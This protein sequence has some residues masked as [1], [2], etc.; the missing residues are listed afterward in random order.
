MVAL[1]LPVLRDQDSFPLS[2]YPMYAHDRGREVAIATAIGVT[3]TG[4]VQR[5]SLTTIADADDPLEA[6]SLVAGEVRAG[7]ADVL[8]GAVARRL[9]DPDLTVQVVTERHD[10]VARTR[11]E[12]SL[13]DRTVHAECRVP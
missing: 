1:A 6:A 11:G 13:F 4:D 12:P 5:L 9:D 2:T 10:V 7:R 8:C 3:A